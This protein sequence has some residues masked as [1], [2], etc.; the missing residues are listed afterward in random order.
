MY[1]LHYGS[2]YCTVKILVIF[3]FLLLIVFLFT[4]F[5]YPIFVVYLFVDYSFFSLETSA[6]CQNDYVEIRVNGP[7]GLLIGRYC[8]NQIPTNQTASQRLWIRFRSNGDRPGAG[9]MAQYNSR[10]CY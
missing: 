4:F 6:G 5:L 8:G 10:E 3:Y 1:N 9:F 7:S 2:N